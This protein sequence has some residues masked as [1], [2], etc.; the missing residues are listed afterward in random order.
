MATLGHAQAAGWPLS[1]LVEAVKVILHALDSYI[2]A[3]LDALR[4]QHLREGALTLLAYQAV[5]GAAG[6]MHRRH[7]MVQQRAGWQPI[8]WAFHAA[9]LRAWARG[10]RSVPRKEASSSLVHQ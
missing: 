8:G 2:L 1:H 6:N 3:I 5:P 10:G 9:S 7:P 4:F